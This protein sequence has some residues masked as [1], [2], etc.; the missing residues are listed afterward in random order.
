MSEPI[1]KELGPYR[2]L[3][4]IGIG[5]MAT[6]YKAYHAATDR[7]VAV[8]V[9]S[10]RMGGDEELRKRFQREAKV[11]ARLEHAH[12][13][14]VYDHGRSGDRLYLVMRYIEAGT[15]KDRLVD[16]A[17][18][19]AQVSRIIGQV[20]GALEY[21]HRLGVV[22]R[23]VKPSNV[24]ID[25]Q[26]DCYLTDF[27]LARIIEASVRLTATG[28]GIGTPAYMSPEQGQGDRVDA[29]SDIYSL[30]VMLYEMV[31]GQVPYQ[32]ETPL[33]VVLKHISAPL[34]LPSSVK[35]DIPE[36][37]E[38]VILKAMAKNPDDRFQTMGEVVAALDAAVR[39]ARAEASTEVAMGESAPVEVVPSSTKELLART[40]IRVRT[41]TKARW[42][43][44]AVWVAVGV[45]SLLALAFV[46]SRVPVRVQTRG[47]QGAAPPV[48][49][50]TEAIVAAATATPQPTAAPSATS[51]RTPTHTPTSTHTPTATPTSTPLPPTSTPTQTPTASPTLTPTSIPLAWQ[52]IYGGALFPRARVNAV[53]VD[54]RDLDVL[55]AATEG[56]GIY[57]SL[58]GGTSWQ[59]SHSGLGV[60][61]VDSL[62]IDPDDTHTVYASTSEGGVY[63]TTDGGL[64]WRGTSRGIK[65]EGSGTAILLMDPHDSQHL[66]Y[67]G[68]DG[69]YESRD[70]G[71]SWTVRRWGKEIYDLVVDLADGDCIYVVSHPEGGDEV[72]RSKGPGAPWQQLSIPEA[73]AIYG[74]AVAPG[75]PPSVYVS[76]WNRD[77]TTRQVYRSHDGGDSWTPIGPAP[78]RGLL[79]MDP[80]DG[81]TFYLG[82]WASELLVS[83]DGGRS[84][85]EAGLGSGRANRFAF[86]P[87]GKATY[88]GTDNGVYVSVDRGATWAPLNSGLGGMPLD[89]RVDPRDGT[90]LYAEAIPVVFGGFTA[91]SLYRSSDGGAS[92][93]GLPAPE[94]AGLAIDPASGTLYRTPAF[95]ALYRSLDGGVT[96]TTLD[97]SPPAHELTGK[98]V[99]VHPVNG[100]LYLVG[101]E[102][103]AL[104]ST[105]GGLT[106]Q[107]GQFVARFGAE[108]YFDPQGED[109]YLVSGWGI[110]RA[111]SD[112]DQYVACDI[113]RY[114]VTHLAVDPTDSQHVFLATKGG[115]VRVSEDRCA[116]WQSHNRGLGN[117]YV[118]VLA[119]DP[120][121]PDLIY[122]G[123]DGGAYVSYDGGAQWGEVNDGLLG[124]TVV[125]DIEIDA[126]DPSKVYA[127]T[128][129]GIFKLGAR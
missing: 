121:D 89:I 45:V 42:A 5:G 93:Q 88:I 47:E 6:V 122:A 83:Y 73:Y 46:L 12:I 101:G 81:Q 51:T 52:R 80:R 66:Y 2:V 49:T 62:A 17:M 120:I 67:R 30:G 39:L 102:D 77:G 57:R 127:A 24:L 63:K 20:G 75:D 23:D 65:F 43:R 86:A 128:P 14:P 74:L 33:A 48:V 29:R 9:L 34:P 11:I 68:V 4:Q 26:G 70:G 21:A 105:D 50:P 16:G 32:A 55:Y 94:S 104:L 8:K 110:R 123:T 99:A 19:L 56:A 107:Q 85:R 71:A 41:V 116:S 1:G 25:G 58:D 13:L 3:E 106:W 98:I 79:A 84:W 92:W 36:A 18:D 100:N 10:E 28:V 96:W 124:A 111:T 129:Y 113:P 72:H 53:I 37:V 117:D 64:T 44:I 54:P 126:N 69:V 31:T 125:Y 76:A 109:V 40:A 27:G 118:N 22:H 97:L 90:R 15:L 95:P 115:G 114:H 87:T 91:T 59:P 60:A 38:R 112:L 61:Q 103:F 7:Y 108:I 78:N 119:I 82:N 35:P